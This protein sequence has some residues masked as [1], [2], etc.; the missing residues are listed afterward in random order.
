MIQFSKGEGVAAPKGNQY[1]LGNPG[2][3]NKPK[4]EKRYAQMAEVACQ[5]GA[6]DLELAEMFDVCVQTIN[7]W[8]IKHKEFGRVLKAGKEP[9]N[10]RVERSLYNRAVGYSYATE[11]IVTVAQGNNQGSVVERVPIIE[12]V[13]PDTTAALKWLNNRRPDQWRERVEHHAT[14]NTTHTRIN[15]DMSLSDMV[16]S[17]DQKLKALT[18]RNRAQE[19]LAAPVLEQEIIDVDDA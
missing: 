3:G 15:V 7:V 12:H 1:A 17:F 5:L 11:K 9:A 13:P 18:I 4:Y 8:K 16:S 14:V 10:D 2:G 6:T 19:Q